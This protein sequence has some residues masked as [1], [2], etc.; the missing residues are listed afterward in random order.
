MVAMT[1]TGLP[2]RANMFKGLHWLSLVPRGEFS[3]LQKA[4]GFPGRWATP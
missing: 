3:P 4:K 2:G 1:D